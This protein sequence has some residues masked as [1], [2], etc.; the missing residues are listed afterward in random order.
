MIKDCGRAIEIEEIRKLELW[1]CF[2]PKL[3]YRDPCKSPHVPRDEHRSPVPLAVM[4]FVSSSFVHAIHPQW[5]FF[6]FV[7]PRFVIAWSLLERDKARERG[8]E[9]WSGLPPPRRYSLLI[10]SVVSSVP[11]H[12]RGAWLGIFFRS[13]IGRQIREENEREREREKE[14]EWVQYPVCYTISLSGNE[15]RGRRANL[16]MYA[17][18]DDG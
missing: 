1:G 15:F 6:S 18:F 11:R 7:W 3:E 17:L 4:D 5:R 13:P 9:E 12:G 16:S 10:N 8:G 2:R 14:R